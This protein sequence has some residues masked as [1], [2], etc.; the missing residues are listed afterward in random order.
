MVGLIGI[1]ALL[2]ATSVAY[3]GSPTSNS[4]IETQWSAFQA[5]NVSS[6]AKAE[7]TAEVYGELPLET[8]MSHQLVSPHFLMVPGTASVAYALGRAQVFFQSWS[9]W[10]VWAQSF[11]YTPQ[12]SQGVVS[13]N[14]ATVRI[15]PSATEVL[16]P[17]GT[18]S[19]FPAVWHT[20]T[21]Q[22]VDGQ[23][24]I[25]NDSYS[26]DA[27]SAFGPNPD[28]SALISST[29]SDD[30]AAIKAAATPA[31]R[32]QAPAGANNVVYYYPNRSAGVSYAEQYAD[33]YNSL[34]KSYAP[35]DCA[36]F[37]NQS[38]WAEFGGVNTSTAINGHWAPMLD[39]DPV[40]GI[41][42]WADSTSTDPD[43]FWTYTNALKS[44]DEYNYN[45]N[46]IGVQGT[47]ENINTVQAG[48]WVWQQPASDVPHVLFVTGAGSPASW[49]NIYVSAHTNNVDNVWIGNV[50]GSQSDVGFE[51][52]VGYRAQ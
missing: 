13:G 21:L 5:S 47:P 41:N 15:M 7:E 46:A 48:D 23:W 39:N 3:A 22:Q 17:S 30:M 18:E 42:W 1:A 44:D 45:N 14:T 11:D 50:Y 49:S 26:D 37:V 2:A 25:S 27:S 4:Q 40:G 12:I 9:D 51:A 33:N 20:L 28:W 32:P 19:N 31:V 10:G 29:H 16:G 36:D 34:F 38:I 8:S 35:D 52:I 6:L 24:L 43:W